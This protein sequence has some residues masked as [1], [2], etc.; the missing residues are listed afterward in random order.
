MGSKCCL[1]ANKPARLCILISQYVF[2]MTPKLFPSLPFPFLLLAELEGASVT[3]ERNVKGERIKA[4]ERD[5]VQQLTVP[6][7]VKLGSRIHPS[8]WEWWRRSLK[9]LRCFPFQQDEVRTF[10][11]LYWKGKLCGSKTLC[12]KWARRIWQLKKC[13]LQFGRERGRKGAL[14]GNPLLY[15]SESP[16]CDYYLFH[17]FIR[18]PNFNLHICKI[19]I[20][21][22]PL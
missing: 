5:G 4:K 6:F 7:H 18:W 10:K 19:R 20:I 21:L 17:E 15:E 1:L 12:C 8:P 14:S 3:K 22:L 2:F 11:K 9:P 16:S 13:L